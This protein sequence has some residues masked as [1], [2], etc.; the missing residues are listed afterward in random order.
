MKRVSKPGLFVFTS[1]AVAKFVL[2]FLAFENPKFIF[3][4]K[5]LYTTAGLHSLIEIYF[6]L[7]KTVTKRTKNLYCCVAVLGPSQPSM[8]MSS[9]PVNI[10]LLFLPGCGYPIISARTFADI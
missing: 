2:F 6:L 4:F 3:A 9:R 1:V 7:L 10:L 8:V 5:H